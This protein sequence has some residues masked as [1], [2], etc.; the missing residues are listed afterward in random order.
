M[1]CSCIQALLGALFLESPSSSFTVKDIYDCCL[2]GNCIQDEVDGDDV[3]VWG[4]PTVYVVR[5]NGGDEQ[6]LR[7]MMTARSL[8]AR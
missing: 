2:Q 8:N 1:A 6:R 5:D 4:P 3:D 7:S